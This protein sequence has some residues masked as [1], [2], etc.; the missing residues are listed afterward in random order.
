MRTHP[1]QYE[2]LNV[3]MKRDMLSK[4][5]AVARDTASLRFSA[6]RRIRLGGLL[7]Q[8]WA[9]VSI[10]RIRLGGLLSAYVGIRQHTFRGGS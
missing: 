9:Y 3:Q 6:K 1:A 4:K 10:H 7:R 5:Q 2:D 8:A